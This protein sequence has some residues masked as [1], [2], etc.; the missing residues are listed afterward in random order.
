MSF[1]FVTGDEHYF[2]KPESALYEKFLGIP[3]EKNISGKKEW[4]RLMEN[5]NVFHIKK[6]YGGDVEQD[7]Y[8]QWCDTLGEERV[9][10]IAAP[11]AC[12]DVILG[13]IALTSGT[14]NL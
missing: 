7:I 1:F 13:A 9:L 8:K 2:D 6:D 5:Y 3:A 10:K 12:I 4:K 11:K 14:K